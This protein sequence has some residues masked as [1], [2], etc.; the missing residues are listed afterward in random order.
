MA[1]DLQREARVDSWVGGADE[2]NPSPRPSEWR[3]GLRA[4]MNGL[5]VMSGLLVTIVLQNQIGFATLALVAG[6]IAAP[7]V[8]AV[9]M[10]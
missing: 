1:E 2:S 5:W 3:Y 10:R 4:V 7:V 6:V 8:A 9:A